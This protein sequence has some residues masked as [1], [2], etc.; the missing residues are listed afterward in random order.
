M[1]TGW[2]D[3]ALCLDSKSG[4]GKMYAAALLLNPPLCLDSKSGG[5]KIHSALSCSSLPLCLDSKSGGGKMPSVAK[6]YP[7]A[8]CLDSKSGGGKIGGRKPPILPPLRN[9]TRAG[10]VLACVRVLTAWRVRLG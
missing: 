4:G 5:G 6:V 8:I 3:G 7:P 2:T 9:F 10:F 1:S